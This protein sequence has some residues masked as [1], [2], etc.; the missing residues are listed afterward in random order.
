[1]NGITMKS[2][3]V[4]RGLMRSY[5]IRKA[6]EQQDII[7]SVPVFSKRYGAAVDELEEL[8]ELLALGHLCAEMGIRFRSAWRSPGS[9]VG[10]S[11]CCQRGNWPKKAP[12]TPCLLTTRRG[13]S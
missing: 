4:D 5:L 7:D 3:V 1:M 2:N 11:S 12:M 13:P 8:E 9:R 6:Q 10:R